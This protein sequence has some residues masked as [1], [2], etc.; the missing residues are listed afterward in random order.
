MNTTLRRFHPFSRDA[1][2]YRSTLAWRSILLLGT[3]VGCSSPSGRQPLHKELF[4]FADHFQRTAARTAMEVQGKE[5][6]DRVDVEWLRIV[7]LWRSRFVQECNTAISRDNPVRGLL[8]VWM[9]SRRA[10]D[11]FET[12]E[13]TAFLG[14][15]QPIVQNAARRVHDRVESIAAFYLKQQVF[16]DMRKKVTERANADPMRSTFP[17]EPSFSDTEQGKKTLEVL[18]GLVEIPVRVVGELLQAPFSAVGLPRGLERASDVVEDFPK[19]AREQ[20]QVLADDL[21]GRET[22]RKAVDSFERFSKSS[23]WLTQALGD[24]PETAEE[25][26]EE[27]DRSQPVSGATLGEVRETAQSIERTA[28]G[29]PKAAEALT[30]LAEAIGQAAKDIGALRSTPEDRGESAPP[31]SKEPFNFQQMTDSAEAWTQTAAEWRGLVRDL[32]DFLGPYPLSGGMG[33]E[34]R[35]VITHAALWAIL[36]MA[37]PFVLMLLYRG[38]TNRFL[39]IRSTP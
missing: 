5:Y 4:R 3:L 31:E 39:T 21:E 26:T 6:Q 10:L 38:I 33:A 20:L 35:C 30:A 15:S 2:P 17:D 37:L 14:E 12:K 8:D 7:E 22:V 36:L 1:M 27:V 19:E 13:S 18:L 28:A 16:D 23:E 29:V 9:L 24:K 25:S 34:I 11:Y 32:R